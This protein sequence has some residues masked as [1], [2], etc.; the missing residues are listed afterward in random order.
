M[1]HQLT[2]RRP[3]PFAL[4]LVLAV[5]VGGAAQ[6][7]EPAAE[8]L[9]TAAELQTLVAPV[10]L[11]PDTLLIQIL[12]GATAPLDVVKA[13]RLLSRREGATRTRSRPRSRPRP[14][15]PASRS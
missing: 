12:V 14:S 8:E 9:L 4:G 2:V 7:Q 6:A 3:S 5:A 15:T 10:A 1:T 11:Y 13:D